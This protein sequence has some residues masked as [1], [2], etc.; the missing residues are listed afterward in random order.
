MVKQGEYK[1][2]FSS[3]STWDLIRESSPLVPW[4]KIVWF[5]QAVPRYSFV[6]W[7][8]IRD[9][10]STGQRM[11]IWGQT[12]AFLSSPIL[13]RHT[14]PD[15]SLTLQAIIRKTSPVN[16]AALLRL[17]FQTVI[18]FVWRERNNRIHKSSHSSYQS[19]T[20]IIEKSISDRLKSL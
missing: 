11:R 9:R 4:S 8:A 1:R 15:W 20:T 2:G 14:N 6:T 19:L 18:Y 5:R 12:Q 10:L 16:D 13:R 7:L 17:L 3:K